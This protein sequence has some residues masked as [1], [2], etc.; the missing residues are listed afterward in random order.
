MPICPIIA[1]F[2]GKG[3]FLD[4]IWKKSFFAHMPKNVNISK[5]RFFFWDNFEKIV[6]WPYIR[7]YQH[8]EEKKIFLLISL[9]ISK[10]K[11]EQLF[12]ISLCINTF[13]S[14][15]PRLFVEN[16]VIDITLKKSFSLHIYDYI[17]IT[18]KIMLFQ[19]IFKN[20]FLAH[21]Y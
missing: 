3:C 9:Q 7:K 10:F 15:C 14:I 8:F 16:Y 6:F 13:L 2:R 5:K 17:N 18:S 21:I 12:F 19:I 4:I 11:E 20:S 1:I